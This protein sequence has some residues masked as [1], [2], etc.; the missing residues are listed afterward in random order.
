M[1]D[2]VKLYKALGLDRPRRGHTRDE[3][4]LIRRIFLFVFSCLF[5]SVSL[6]RLISFKCV[7]INNP[8]SSLAPPVYFEFVSIRAAGVSQAGLPLAGSE[9]S[10]GIMGSP[11]TSNAAATWNKISP[12]FSTIF[13]HIWVGVATLRCE[14]ARGAMTRTVGAARRRR[15]WRP[16]HATYFSGRFKREPTVRL[17][18]LYNI[19]LDSIIRAISREPEFENSTRDAASRSPR[20]NTGCPEV[21]AP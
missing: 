3:G 6:C 17:R 18:F 1:E 20:G 21:E 15:G 13:V 10:P 2:V 12:C 16:W 9:K 11:R 19:C 14:S 4:L 8:K 5:P 7:Q